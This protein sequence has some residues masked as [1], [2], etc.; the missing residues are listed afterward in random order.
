MRYRSFLIALAILTCG[1]VVLAKNAGDLL[2]Q[3]LDNPKQAV[4]NEILAFVEIV[5][6]QTDAPSEKGWK[7]SGTLNLKTIEAVSGDLPK[8]FSVRFYKRHAEGEDAWTWDYTVLKKGKR[9]LGFFN[10]WEK[11]WAVRQDGRRNVINN[12]EHLEQK[13]LDRTQILFKTPLLPKKEEGAHTNECTLQ[14]WARPFLKVIQIVPRRADAPRNGPDELRL[15]RPIGATNSKHNWPY[16]YIAF[17][18]PSI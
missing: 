9:L 10:K 13:L 4:K 14:K 17:L 5:S 12:P 11:I 15:I 2:K 18:E 6:V 16:I 3:Y 7:Q 8:T 1:S